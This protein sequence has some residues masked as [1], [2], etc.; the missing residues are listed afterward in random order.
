MRKKDP[1]LKKVCTR[2][3]SQVHKSSVFNSS[4]IQNQSANASSFMLD[5]ECIGDPVP[6]ANDSVFVSD[7]PGD[8]VAIAL[9]TVVIY[10]C[11]D[12]NHH[13]SEADYF[14]PLLSGYKLKPP[15]QK[16]WADSGSGSLPSV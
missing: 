7:H 12:S 2:E 5:K 9:S 4:R 13:P 3:S 10:I 8:A 15:Q 6:L 16:L 11:G 1:K 14:K